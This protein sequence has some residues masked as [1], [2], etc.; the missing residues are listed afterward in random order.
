MKEMM[1][2]YLFLYTQY[3]VIRENGEERELE[4]ERE[5]QRDGETGE[6]RHC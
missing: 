4:K 3:C 6:R 1:L 2:S 5:R